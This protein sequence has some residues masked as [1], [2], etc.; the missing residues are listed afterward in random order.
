MSK[1]KAFQSKLFVDISGSFVKIA[2][3]ALAEQPERSLPI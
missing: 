2:R 3:N 1:C